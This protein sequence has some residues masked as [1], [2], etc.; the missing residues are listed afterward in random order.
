MVKIEFWTVSVL[1]LKITQWLLL[2]VQIQ[3]CSGQQQT[4]GSY[5]WLPLLCLHSIAII[6][7][8]KH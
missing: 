2:S 1:H 6:M 8:K 4:K 7:T 3:H 5:Y